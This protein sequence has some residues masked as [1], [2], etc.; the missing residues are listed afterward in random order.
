LGPIWADFR[1]TAGER[2]VGQFRPYLLATVSSTAVLIGASVAPATAQQPVYTWTG[3]YIGLNVGAGSNN[4]DFSQTDLGGGFYF[5]GGQ[6]FW[7]SDQWGASAGALAGYNWQSGNF[8]F[9]IEGD[10]NWLNGRDSATLIFGNHR[11][12]TSINWYSTAR[13]RIGFTTDSPLHVYLTGGVAV[14]EVSNTARN[15]FS[16]QQFRTSDIRIAP[17][18]GLGFEYKVAQNTTVRL[19]GLFADF[20]KKSQTIND[21]GLYKTN[22]SN[23]LSVVRG[24][25]TWAW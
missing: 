6:D 18:V 25:V 19:E 24:A 12:S 4:A 22:F 21:G 8:V 3:Y 1:I 9:G 14:A 11:T 17:V 5:P 23:A 15:I 10:V 7:S 16:T 2:A 20:G 13:A